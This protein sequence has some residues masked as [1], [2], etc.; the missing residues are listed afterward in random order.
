MAGLTPSPALT[1]PSVTPGSAA[2]VPPYMA[3]AGTS[4]LEAPVNADVVKIAAN[5]WESCAGDWDAVG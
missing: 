4:P 1:M 2:L 3:E 5:A